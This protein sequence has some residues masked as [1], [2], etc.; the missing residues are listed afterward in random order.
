MKNY[1]T[2]KLSIM[3][4]GMSLFC[5]LPGCMDVVPTTSRSPATSPS[6]A[7][8]TRP[9]ESPSL[10][11]ALET[12]EPGAEKVSWH[13]DG[14]TGTLTFSGTGPLAEEEAETADVI[15]YDW[16]E[17]SSDVT[18]IVMEEGITRIPNMAFYGFEGVTEVSL[19]S[20]VKSIGALAFW[21]C[22][23]ST[24]ELPEGLE[25]IESYA[26]SMCKKLEACEISPTVTTLDDGVFY[27]CVNL[28]SLILH[29]GLK[30]IGDGCFRGCD[31]LTA[32]TVPASVTS[33][34]DLS[35]SPSLWTLVFLGNPPVFAKAENGNYL[36]VNPKTI[37]NTEGNSL[38]TDVVD[39][40]TADYLTW[41]EGFPAEGT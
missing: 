39:Q 29:E 2:K 33:I 13:F 14:A 1:F 38:W 27:D 18:S 24:L 37:Y 22:N 28:S 25:N 21:S 23:F 30:S 8:V 34:G 20:T 4:L 7:P 26:F 11:P 17:L 5:I 31:S 10:P 6:S 19:S 15:D 36:L 41:I 32:L 9:V 3:V 16:H 40:S 12:A 35:G